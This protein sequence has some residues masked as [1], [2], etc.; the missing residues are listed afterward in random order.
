M[1][2][3]LGG[4][5]LN[6]NTE[7]LSASLA[8]FQPKI[9]DNVKTRNVTLD[10]LMDSKELYDGGTEIAVRFRYK[11]MAKLGEA[12]N[13]VGAYKYYQKLN[14]SPSDTIK[15]G[16]EV[17]SNLN[18]PISLSNQEKREN[19][20]KKE[21]DR[22]KEKTEEAMDNL[23]ENVN[24]I[25]W[26]VAGGD[27]SLLPTPITDIVSGTDSLTLHGFPKASNTW[28][29]SQSSTS[30][31]DAA[32]FLLEKMTE[33]FNLAVDN[34]PNK[35]DALDIFLMAREPFQVL[36][37]I[38]PAYI[39]YDSNKNVDV[40]FPTLIHMGK[41]VRFDSTIPKDANQK[42]Q[43]F[44]LMKKYWELAIDREINFK[45]T[46]FYDMLPEQHAVCAQL[47]LTFAVICNNPRTN[48]RGTGVEV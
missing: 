3:G 21:F 11:K 35:S 24:D 2:G 43:V 38:M 34:A 27:Q 8:R 31:G 1:G 14:T 37:N 32:D 17:W 47:F 48:W 6:Q 28:L 44:G 12:G 33:G 39:T 16:R 26:G 19:A 25:L 36:Q 13:H 5:S 15:N 29:N 46:Q 18:V 45:T 7:R 4:V 23:A 20:G 9:A 30:I 10:F 42:Y 41:P 40:G 22:L